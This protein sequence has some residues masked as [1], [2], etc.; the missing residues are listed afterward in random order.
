MLI[1]LTVNDVV[2][3]LTYLQNRN[4]PT[5]QTSPI[6]PFARHHTLGKILNLSIN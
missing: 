6:L 3:G 5:E 4:S 1:L 2:A